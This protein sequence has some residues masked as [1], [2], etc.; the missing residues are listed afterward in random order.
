MQTH[1]GATLL[2]ELLVNL[3]VFDDVVAHILTDIGLCLPGAD[4]EIP[5][6]L[7]LQVSEL[8]APFILELLQIF[9]FL[10]HIHFGSQFQAMKGS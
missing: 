4:G 3:A 1:P 5:F 2:H 8:L 7:I 6:D 9:L 10:E